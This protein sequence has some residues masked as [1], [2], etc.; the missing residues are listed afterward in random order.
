M[1]V[2][3][4]TRRAAALAAPVRA[5]G[6]TTAAPR[7]LHRRLASRASRT[8]RAFT[9]LEVMVALSIL[10]VSV[11][12]VFTI[13]S[14]SIYG[15][16][17]AKKLT[18]ATLLARSKMTDLE[19]N[20]YDKGF[21]ADDDE[22][23]G[24]FTEEGWPSYKWRA[25]IV[26]P[27]TN[28]MSP[29]QLIGAIF[30]LPMGGGDS[31]D[32]TGG[33][34]SAFGGMFGGGKLPPGA[35]PGSG[36]AGANIAGAMGPAA[37]LMQG[38]FQQ[39]V[40]QI[41][42]SVREVHLTVTWKEGKITESFDIVTHVVSLGPGSD[43]NGGAMAQALAQAGVN[44]N[45]AQPGGQWVRQ[46][47]GMPVANPTPA[48]NGSGMVDPASGVPVITMEQWNMQR[49]GAAGIPGAGMLQ[50]GMLGAPGLKGIG[51]LPNLGN[52]P[53]GRLRRGFGE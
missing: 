23:A 47:N 38:Q 41:T 22:E 5:H 27:K 37:G 15:H 3:S 16:V 39:L 13:N 30:N 28:G 1:R 21:Q 45:A 26:A 29:D 42:K 53:G 52:L 33:L 9:L 6:H 2:E 44:P 12:A 17:Y 14:S 31:K 7:A 51:G 35:L 11:T 19:Q 50:P 36:N 8:R 34:M 32:G 40:D 24:D 10:A 20:L 43:R 46:D 4:D 25:K 48:P 49:G 18:V